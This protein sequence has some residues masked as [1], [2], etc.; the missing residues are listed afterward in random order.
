M[1]DNFVL[2]VH[3][4]AEVSLARRNRD[5]ETS[6]AVRVWVKSAKANL[7]KKKKERY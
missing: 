2:L 6:S 4:D 3:M 1:F 7:E 5:H